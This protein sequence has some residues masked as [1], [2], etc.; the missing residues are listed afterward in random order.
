MLD[1]YTVGKASRISP[2][3]PVAVVHVHHE[4]H[5]AGGAGNVVLNLLALGVNVSVLGRVGTDGPGTTLIDALNEVDADCSGIVRQEGYL[6]PVKN[7]VISDSQQIVRVDREQN[8]PL[9]PLLEQQIC[10]QIPEMLAGIQLVAISDYGKG[11]LTPRLL[12]VLIDE[13]QERHIPIITDPK[14][15]DFSKYAGSTIIKP[16][17]SEALAASGLEHGSPLPEVAER[18]LQ[19]TQAKVLMITRSQDGISLYYPNGHQE[20]LPVKIREIKDVTGA[21]DTVLAMVSCGLASGLDL[22]SCCQLANVAAGIAIERFG[23]ARVSLSDVAK[24]QAR[25][26][27]ILRPDSKSVIT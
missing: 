25:I 19:L 20:N 14:G 9:D 8:S 27:P 2:E 16:N 4:E 3:A 26:S 13:A 5:R 23:C 22:G 7:R 6:T 10:G 11:L 12:R 21:G 24:R 15:L 1:T 17:L 18:L